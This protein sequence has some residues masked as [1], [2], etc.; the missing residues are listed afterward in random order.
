MAGALRSCLPLRGFHVPVR[1][2]HQ[3]EGG[4]GSREPHT[5]RAVA[6]FHVPVR[7]V[8]QWTKRPQLGDLRVLGGE[9]GVMGLNRANEGV[10]GR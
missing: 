5:T 10:I 4:S 7:F 1:F 8:H 2:V 3:C 9:K 6:P